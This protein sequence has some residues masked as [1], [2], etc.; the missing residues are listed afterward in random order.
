MA[1][2]LAIYST[3]SARMPGEALAQL[4]PG[5]R[6]TP[7]TEDERQWYDLVW[8]R[9]KVTVRHYH[10]GEADFAE[11]IRGFLGYVLHAAQGDMDSRLWEIYYQVSKAR[12]GFGLAIEPAFDGAICPKLVTDLAEVG[13][14]FVFSS[15]SLTDPWGRLLLGPGNQRGDGVTY[16]FDSAKERRERACSRLAMLGLATPDSLPPT[17]ADEE[18]LLRDAAEVARRAVVLLAVAMRA[19]GIAQPKVIKFLQQR[20]VTKSVSPQEKEFLQQ[21]S[22]DEAQMRKLTW[23]YEALWTLLWALAR[24]D[25]LGPPG[26]QCDAR[27]AIKLVNETPSDQLIGQATLR[28]ASEILDELDFYYRAHWHAVNAQQ[29]GRPSHAGLDPDVI[30]ERHYALNWLATYMYQ[31]WDDVGTDT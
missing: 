18:A 22:P 6:C 28:P 21:A 1:D 3:I 23:R 13:C 14:G 10:C 19:E 26:S 25:E 7:R 17:V 9:L 15:D 4:A 27:R 2:N 16:I 8:P 24:I 30:F 31:A 5:A 12:Q 20:G 29:E 11:H